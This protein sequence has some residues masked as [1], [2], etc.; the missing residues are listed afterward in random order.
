MAETA[1]KT[2]PE[3]KGKGT[4]SGSCVCDREWRGSMVN[5]EWQDCNCAKDE[6]CPICN[7]KGVVDEPA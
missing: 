7:G 6:K 5:E 1:K 4:I 2:C 3:C